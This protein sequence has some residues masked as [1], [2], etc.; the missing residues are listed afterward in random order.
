MVTLR[1]SGVALALSALSGHFLRAG[2][3]VLAGLVAGSIVLL[4]LKEGWARRL[5]Q[6]LLAAA[7]LVWVA[8]AWL[9]RDPLLLGGAIWS[10]ASIF[11][12]HG[13]LMDRRFGLPEKLT[14]V[15]PDSRLY[16][17]V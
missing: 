4:S 7:A 17:L 11:L 5:V 6:G 9:R 2:H 10:S 13:S 1:L 8:A 12:L 3:G 16:T 14:G 15:K